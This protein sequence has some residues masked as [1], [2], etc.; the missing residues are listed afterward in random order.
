MH[1]IFSSFSVGLVAS[2]FAITPLVTPIIT[3]HADV[4][5]GCSNQNQT[6]AGNQVLTQDYTVKAGQTV[7][8]LNDVRVA[9]NAKLTVEKGAKLIV[10]D[11]LIAQDNSVINN[12]GTIGGKEVNA[13]GDDGGDATI[14][15]YHLIEAYHSGQWHE[16]KIKNA[17]GAI[18]R[19]LKSEPTIDFVRGEIVTSRLTGATVD[20]EF[21]DI[22]TGQKIAV[23]GAGY[24]DLDRYPDLYGKAGYLRQINGL[25]R[26]QT[27]I[28]V[29]EYIAIPKA[30]DKRF[31][32]AHPLKG[33]TVKNGLISGLKQG[34]TYQL[35]RFDLDSS[36]N[37]R[38][39]EPSSTIQIPIGSHT[40][41]CTDKG[42]YELTASYVDQYGG[43]TYNQ[44]VK[45]VVK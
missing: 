19:P 29:K 16:G 35:T 22:I 10:K 8:Y 9:K 39:P 41:N 6:I 38:T 30:N 24:I 45:F 13:D 23:A 18:L 4:V 42:E 31:E 20:Y 14:N 12:Y 3:T 2:T 37:L 25:G 40:Y 28:G 33:V 27:E 21:E 32:Q 15:N 43:V 34:F 1:K 26:A 5:V 7:T 11:A 44:P 36:G 17:P